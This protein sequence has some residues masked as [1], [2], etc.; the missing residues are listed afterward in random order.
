MDH[1][2]GRTRGTAFVHYDDISSA[3]AALQDAYKFLDKAK[4]KQGQ[5]RGYFRGNNM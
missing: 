4:I 5:G 2:T 3:D 1:V